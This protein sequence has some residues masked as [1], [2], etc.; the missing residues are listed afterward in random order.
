MTTTLDTPGTVTIAEPYPARGFLHDSWVIARRGLKHLRRQPEALTDATIQPVMFVLMFGYVFGGAIAIPGGGSYREFLMGGI[1]AQ[2]MVFTAFGVALSL[3]NDRRNNAVDRF[4]S[5]PI[6]R[7]SVL[8][9]HAIAN[10]LKSMLPILLMSLCGLAIGWRIRSSF[11]DALVGYGLL[12]GF[13]FTMIWVGVLLG[14]VVA[15]PEGVNGVAF[16]ALFPLTFVASTFV[17]TATMPGALKVLA[18][19][20]PVTTLSDALRIQ[21]ANPNT[22]ATAADPWPIRHPVAYT[23]I[24]MV[25]IVVVCAPL[26]VRAYDRSI[27][28]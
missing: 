15:T 24:W 26:A 17:P 19:W 7:G 20:N 27:R 12:I 3:A 6:A 10:L 9:G 14:S 22:P 21:F 4:R 1:F 25:G 28:K 18:E 13:S 5:L 16:V 2:T 11:V 8:A 23:V